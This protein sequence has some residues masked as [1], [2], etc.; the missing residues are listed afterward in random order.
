VK[1]LLSFKTL[2]FFLLRY[3]DQSSHIF[4]QHKS[5]SILQLQSL[6]QMH[7]LSSVIF[8]LFEKLANIFYD[9]ANTCYEEG[10]VS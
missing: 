7:I 5:C 6:N 2:L 10:K 1:Y 3:I 8:E 9:C 4:Y